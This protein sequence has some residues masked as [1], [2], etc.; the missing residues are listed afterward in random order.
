MIK[1]DTITEPPAARRRTP[2]PQRLLF[3]AGAVAP[4]SVYVFF[5]ATHPEALKKILAET[6]FAFAM[7]V[8]LLHLAVAAMCGAWALFCESKTYKTAFSAGL[9]L[10]AIIISGGGSLTPAVTKA[11]AEPETRVAFNGPFVPLASVA[12]LSTFGRAL[13][14]VFNPVGVVIAV[15][16]SDLRK[17]NAVLQTQI[18]QMK[19]DA[20]KAVTS[21]R[22]AGIS[23]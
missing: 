4:L 19:L 12:E 3:L 11:F 23:R 22:G 14:F 8:C 16:T 20:Q 6:T 17:K 7:I 10:P 1:T 13:S 15:E 5:F 2:R 9:A 18:D 21:Q